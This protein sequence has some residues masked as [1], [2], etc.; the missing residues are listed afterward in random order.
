[1][2]KACVITGSRAE[3]GLLK[4]LISEISRNDYFELQIIATGMHLSPEYGLTFREIEK[5]GF[6]ITEKIE[7]D[8]SDNTPAGITRAMGNELAGF[9]AAYQRLQPDIVVLLGDRY[10]IFIAAAAAMMGGIPIAHLCGGEITAG[11]LDDVIRHCITKMSYLHFASS[12]VYRKRIIQLGEAPDRVYCFGDVGVENI[13][14]VNLLSKP[15][16]ETELGFSLA[17][18]YALVTF[19][20]ETLNG[21]SAGSQFE[22]L[23]KALD[24]FSNVNIIFT[25]ANSD[26][27]GDMINCM[28]ED[29]VRNHPDFSVAYSSMG[30]LR[31]LSALKYAA[32]VIGNS[33]SGIVEAPAFGVPS[34]NIGNRQE[35]RL[36]ASSIIDCIVMEDSIRDA[37]GR[38]LSDGFRTGLDSGSNPYQ[39]ENVAARIVGKVEEFLRDGKIDLMKQFYDL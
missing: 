39:G 9:A 19:H 25:K 24:S 17:K 34:V 27:G 8:L 21:S 11:A 10:E 6:V 14:K 16:L 1:M 37:I 4:G 29:Y 28:I 31:Y 36:K 26:P 5:D 18:K 13:R 33:S 38:A 32:A 30:Q 15:E 3:Y 35:G 23:L 2:K 12:E 22:C 7:M 20:P